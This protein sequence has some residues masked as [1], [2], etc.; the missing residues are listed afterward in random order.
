MLFAAYRRLVT[1][2]VM[3]FVITAG[4]IA[5]EML[6]GEPPD[7]PRVAV[8]SFVAPDVVVAGDSV[9][10]EM[11]GSLGDGVVDVL[12][13]GAYGVMRFE[14]AIVE[15]QGRLALPPAVTRQA[16]TWTVESGELAQTLE[17]L[18]REAATLVAPLVGPRTIVANGADQTLAVL[19]PTDRFG[20]QVADGTDSTIAWEQPGGSTSAANPGVVDGMAWALIP[21]GQVAGLTTVRATAGADEGVR[22]SAVRIDEVP[23]VVRDITLT[24]SEPRGIADGRS[25]VTLHTNQLVDAF[26]NTLADGTIAHFIFDGPSGRGMLNSTVQNGVVH[27]A[28]HAPAS[29]GKLTGH[30]VIHG[31]E[32]NDVEIDF[33]TAIDGFDARIEFIGDEALLRIE[34]ALDPSGAFVADGTEVTWGDLRGSVRRGSAEIWIPAALADAEAPVEILG[35]AADVELGTP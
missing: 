13:Q 5:A 31:T 29:P 10:V 17:V 8:E 4:D 28:V 30:V 2:L 32:S 15:G 26:G 3:S 9:V 7:Q 27:I 12:L 35:L 33:A 23:G 18:P 19:L 20:N 25:V 34:H 11:S 16:G 22:A 24:A 21:S 6:T 14:V 1:V